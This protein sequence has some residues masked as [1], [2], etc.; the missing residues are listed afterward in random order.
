MTAACSCHDYGHMSLQ[1]LSM[2]LPYFVLFF[3]LARIVAGS[4]SFKNTTRIAAKLAFRLFNALQNDAA[5]GAAILRSCRS[6]AGAP[7]RVRVCSCSGPRERVGREHS[8]RAE[9]ALRQCHECL[10]HAS[11]ELWAGHCQFCCDILY[12]QH[13]VASFNGKALPTDKHPW[14]S[15]DSFSCTAWQTIPQF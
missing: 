4:C 11:S 13:L 7:A 10:L 8:E 15:V 3:Q 5:V 12:E 14:K 1:R 2:A 6:G 9:P